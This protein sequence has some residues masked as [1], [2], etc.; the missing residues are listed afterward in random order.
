[1]RAQITERHAF[2]AREIP[3]PPTPRERSVGTSI[4]NGFTLLELLV[5][6]G[7]IAIIAS[8]MFASIS[9]AKHKA[10]DADCRGNLRQLALAMLVYADDSNRGRLPT[11]AEAEFETNLF[12]RVEGMQKL[13]SRLFRCRED[14]SIELSSYTWNE[15]LGG[16]LVHEVSDKPEVARDWGTGPLFSDIA[17]WHGH[18]NAVFGDSHVEAVQQ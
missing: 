11:L 7:I 3:S 10:R 18:K 1:M 2:F 17:P 8:L 16:K 12:L 4:V 9:R 15:S 5:V 6:I 14:K 13:P